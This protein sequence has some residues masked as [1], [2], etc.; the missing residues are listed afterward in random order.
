MTAFSSSSVFLILAAD[1]GLFDDMPSSFTIVRNGWIL[2]SRKVICLGRRGI[3]ARSPGA[4]RTSS[5]GG[6][7]LREFIAKKKF[8]R[9]SPGG[10]SVFSSRTRLKADHYP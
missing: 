8:R 3:F 7:D 5:C 1:Q 4:N 10:I 6:N 2:A 9:E